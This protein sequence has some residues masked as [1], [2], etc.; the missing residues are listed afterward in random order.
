MKILNIE[1][2]KHHVVSLCIESADEAK[3]LYAI[4]N[5]TRNTDL[6]GQATEDVGIA[7]KI[8]KA[9]GE[10]FYANRGEDIIPGVSYIDFYR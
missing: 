3:A 6:L 7:L 9:V 2:D 4:F 5:H 8:R 1:T 10:C